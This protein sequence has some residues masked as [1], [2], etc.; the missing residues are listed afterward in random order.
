MAETKVFGVPIAGEITSMLLS[1]ISTTVLT[2]FISR[3]SPAPAARPRRPSSV[4]TWRRDA[5]QREGLSPSKS[6]AGFRSFPG[7][8]NGRQRCRSVGRGL[9]RAVDAVVFAIYVDSYLFV[10]ATAILQHAIGINMSLATCE[11][12]ILLCLVCYV[13]TKHI[14]R[15]TPKRR[16][17]SRLYLF[18]SFGM[19]GVYLVVAVL[20]FVFRIAKMEDGMCVIGMKSLAMIPLISFDAVVNIY[21]TFMFIIPLRRLHSFKNMPRSPANMRLRKTAFRTF[22]GALFTLISSVVN[23]TVLMAMGG[24]P[25]WVCLMCCNGD[26][27]FSAIILQWVTT[28]DNHHGPAKISSSGGDTARGDPSTLSHM[29]PP[30]SMED[31]DS[32]FSKARASPNDLELCDGDNMKQSGIVITTTIRHESGPHG[33]GTAGQ[34][35]V[36]ANCSTADGAERASQ[37]F[38]VPDPQLYPRQQTSI[39]AGMRAGVPEYGP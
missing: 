19:L 22:F 12:A 4:L 2:L 11:G 16:L 37:D 15:G 6:G 31:R 32:I 9:T 13:T 30:R 27:L 17:K 1:M 21:L 38:L 39:V 10:F 3:P 29:K 24:Q 26:I 23:L 18:N 36:S 25:G 33:Q 34:G 8:G 14:I 7:V 5:P 35:P 20:N 28:G